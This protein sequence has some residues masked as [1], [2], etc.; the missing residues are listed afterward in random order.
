MGAQGGTSLRRDSDSFTHLG[1][2]TGTYS[3]PDTGLVAGKPAGRRQTLSLRC[4]PPPGETDHMQRSDYFHVMKTLKQGHSSRGTMGTRCYR[5]EV[6]C[7]Q[8]APENLSAMTS[9]WIPEQRDEEMELAMQ[10]CG[11]TTFQAE[12]ELV[13]RL[14]GMD[15]RGVFGGNEGGR[16][17]RPQLGDWIYSNYDGQSGEL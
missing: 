4:L 10:R 3:E 1:I 5:D 15:E 8:G 13:P 17:A 7:W 11:R 9:E 2:A 14:W 12:E 16:G 6:P